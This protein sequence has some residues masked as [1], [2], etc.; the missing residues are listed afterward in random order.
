MWIPE[1]L[2]RKCNSFATIFVDIEA[3]LRISH[4]F[5][6]DLTPASHRIPKLSLSQRFKSESV[7]PSPKGAGTG[8]RLGA[9]IR[10]FFCVL[11]FSVVL[12]AGDRGGADDLHPFQGQVYE[13]VEQAPAG[14]E[15]PARKVG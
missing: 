13:M 11:R 1:I 7:F 9:Q 4:G 3:F 2:F 6:S 14:E 8:K 5:H 15:R 12:V 10:R